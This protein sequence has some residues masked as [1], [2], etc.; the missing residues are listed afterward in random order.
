MVTAEVIVMVLFIVWLIGIWSND[1]RH[2]K[3]HSITTVVHKTA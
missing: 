1:I 2:T 3:R